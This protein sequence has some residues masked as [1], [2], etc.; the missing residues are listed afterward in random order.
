MNDTIRGQFI[1][2][3][4]MTTDAA[5]AA[6]FYRAL[7]GWQT[8]P[9]GHNVDYTLCVAPAGPVA[10]IMALPE[11]A[12]A[13]G[14][15]PSWLPY[16]G[17]PDIEATVAHAQGLGGRV[18]KGVTA[19]EGTG[20]YAVL[21]DPQGASFGVYT[22]QQTAQQPPVGPG[23]F[24][25]HELVTGDIGA[26]LGFYRALFGWGELQ[27]MDMGEVGPYLIF[28]L[29]TT[30]MGGIY[31]SPAGADAPH[32]LGYVS[33]RSA[34]AATATAQ[35]QGAR[36]LH[37]PAD[38]P[39][40]GRITMLIDPQGVAIAV[41]SAKSP[42]AEAPKP[43]ARKP[44]PKAKPAVAAKAAAAVKPKVAAKPKGAA[45]AKAP[46]KR[47]AATRTKAAVKGRARAAARKPAARKPARGA[48]AKRRP[49]AQKAA[50]KMVRRPA[51]RKSARRHR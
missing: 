5:G 39:G 20:R 19:I 33:V 6:G 8:Q 25:W 18:L 37:G 15:P 48:L 2:H 45:K 24:V 44:A 27:R 42:A 38:V 47:K 12:R 34:D 21:A 1:W 46:A 32:W 23:Q 7:T 51:R 13:M 16:V 4:L 41:H 40:G 31:R 30:Q 9:W 10:G 36:V 28:G 22:P 49:A 50:R 11:D 35:A 17:T 3:E 26:A 14:A 29:G 43:A